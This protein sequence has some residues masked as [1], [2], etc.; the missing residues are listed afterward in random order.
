MKIHFVCVGNTYR[1]RLAE[2]YLNAKKLQNVLCISSGI[3]ADN[4]DQ[5]PTSP[6]TQRVLEHH[7]LIRYSKSGWTQTTKSLLD[8]AD[9]TIFF[10]T[11]TYEHCIS[12]FKFHS[13][14]SGVWNIHDIDRDDSE[15]VKNIN[16]EHTFHDIARNIDL[17]LTTMDGK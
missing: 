16:C 13:K 5:G 4:N 14:T 8:W 10:D 6:Y 2:A 12:V 3:H 11:T 1:S 17:L 7:N 15:E 9:V